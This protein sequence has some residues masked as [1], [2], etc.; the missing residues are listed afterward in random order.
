VSH[1]KHRATTTIPIRCGKRAS[2]LCLTVR[3]GW[4]ILPSVDEIYDLNVWF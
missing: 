1:A 3:L 4:E 2:K